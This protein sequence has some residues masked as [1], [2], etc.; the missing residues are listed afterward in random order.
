MDEIEIYGGGGGREDHFLGNLHLL[1]RAHKSG[2]KAKMIT[3]RSLI[4]PASGRVEFTGIKGATISVLPFGGKVHIM[5][6]TGLKYAYPKELCYG[7][8][9]GLSNVVESDDARLEI[10]AGDTAL[11]FVNR[12]EL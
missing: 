2:V 11:I 3:A 10:G 7:V 4:Y 5:G 8:C 1:Y 6:S 12:G 9:R